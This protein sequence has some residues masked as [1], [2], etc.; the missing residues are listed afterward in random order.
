MKILTLVV[1][2]YNSAQ[3]LDK[4][5][6]SMLHTE[7]LDKLEI[8]I[9]N[10][11]STDAT[12]TVAEK[13]VTQHPGTVRLIS[14]ENKGHGGALNSGFAAATGKYI[15]P[16]DADDWIQTQNLPEFIRLL[17]NCDS[18]VVLTP[19]RT[20]DISNGEILSYTCTP[21]RFGVPM[22]M[23]E[24]MENWRNFYQCTVFHGIAYRRDFYQEK[25]LQLSE[26]VFYEDNEYATFPFC[27][28]ETVTALDL[29][30]YEYRI[31]DVTQSMST[32]NQIKRLNHLKHVGQRMLAEFTQLP[33]SSGKD[34]AATKTQAV[35]SLYLNLT[36]L[37]HPDRK[38]GR[39]LAA[40][41]LNTCQVPAIRSIL[42][43][44]YRVLKYLNYLHISKETWDNLLNSGIYNAL[45]KKI[46][47]K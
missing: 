17:E 29:H 34:Y 47:L 25:G 1:P 28:A 11:G 40:E 3:F 4:G 23:D 24:I 2:A 6:P 26:H 9:V 19:Y 5:I 39:T 15:K 43:K 31:G 36:L 32:A 10:D 37:A 27:R 8:I 30:I 22:P 12:K 14:Q 18:D 38:T 41:L 46:S 35:L 7:I 13:Y 45:R 16:I 21:S 42:Q 44:K 20:V 33:D